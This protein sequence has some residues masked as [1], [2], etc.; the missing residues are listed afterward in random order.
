M[1][2]PCFAHAVSSL[3]QRKGA[4]NDR[5]PEFWTT[6]AERLP[7]LY[8][9][10][11]FEG[12]IFSFPVR[13]QG[14]R[15]TVTGIFC[16]PHCAKKYIITTRHVPS[17]CLSLFSHM[18][19]SVYQCP[20]VVTPAPDIETLLYSPAM[21]IAEWRAIPR[22]RI[23]L[24]LQVPHI[25]PFQFQHTQLYGYPADSHPAY[26][27]LTAFSA[28]MAEPGPLPDAEIV[29]EYVVPAPVPVSDEEEKQFSAADAG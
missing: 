19:L 15:Y 2:R 7:C 21:S 18:M 4:F 6:N 23:H 28:V 10:H 8:D 3:L 5:P 24:R 13:R 9:H 27:A 16:S 22:E 20:E 25:V 29:P 1:S 26:K 12:S 17:Q 14:H 11:P